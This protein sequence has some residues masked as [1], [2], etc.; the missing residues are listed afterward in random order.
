MKLYCGKCDNDVDIVKVEQGQHIKANCSDCGSYIKFLSK[1]DKFGTKEQMP[2]IWDKTHGRCAYCGIRLNPNKKNGY[3]IDHIHPQIDGGGHDDDNLHLSCKSCNSQKG[4]K[5]LSEYRNYL[6]SLHEKA[7][8][9]FWFEILEYSH[10]GEI[11]NSN[12][13]NDTQKPKK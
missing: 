5:T 10:F 8:W 6:K 4:A 9:I 2:D 11:E 3:S 7:T 12:Y 1:E 13:N